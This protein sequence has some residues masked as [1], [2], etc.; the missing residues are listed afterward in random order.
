MHSLL[1]LVLLVVWSH[2][3]SS[4]LGLM[5]SLAVLVSCPVELLCIRELYYTYA[6]AT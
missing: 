1:S 4:C 6:R 3:Q 2:A 5:P